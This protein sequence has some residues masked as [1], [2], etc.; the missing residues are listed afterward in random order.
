MAIRGK[1]ILLGL[2]A[3]MAVAGSAPAV[4]AAFAPAGSSA[5]T[6]QSQPSYR[7]AQLKLNF[8][9]TQDDARRLLFES[10]YLDIQITRTSFKNVRAQ[11]CLNG[12]RYEV[13]VRRLSGRVIRGNQIGK[14]RRSYDAQEIAARLKKQGLDKISVSRAGR[15]RFV[16]NACDLEQRVRLD[17]NRYG[18]VLQ[19]SITGRCQR[20]PNIVEIKRQLKDDG[21]TRVQVVEKNPRRLIVEACFSGDK[22]R[23]RLAADGRI[24]QQDII[25]TCQRPIRP[26]NIAQALNR[27]G[28]N[29]VTVIDD[30]LP[31]YK[32]QACRQNSL[33]R[34]RLNRYGEVISASRLGP[35]SP[36]L[37][38]QQVVEML[39]R[40][41]ANRVDILS[42][43][44]RGFRATAC[45]RL[46]RR[47]Y[48]I[49]PYGAIL[50]RQTVGR[51]EQAPRLN[52]VLKDFRSQGMRD[53][54][55][56]VEGCRNGRRLQIEL[57]Q[58]G[59]E[60]NRE[61]IGRC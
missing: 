17:I 33:M 23:L 6:S 35:C 3:M 18:E 38:R 51:C 52:S 53:V 58:F 34:V 36:P 48:R 16:A 47:Q 4:G 8:G 10:G 57:N 50:D 2:L 40:R 30:Q 61:R 24:R 21:F 27:L 28:Y 5:K 15:E 25:G 1:A 37:T 29:R 12:I 14:C 11:A 44:S 55:I 45:Y 43:N 32:A 49:D 13:K 42:S 7:L 59:D 22:V 60:I 31:V 56:L 39:Q 54:R 41:G 46:E 19:R 20:G 26:Q 9:L